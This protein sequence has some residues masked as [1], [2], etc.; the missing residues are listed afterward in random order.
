MKTEKTFSDKTILI[1]GATD[2]L[3]KSVA[4]HLAERGAHLL[5]HGRNRKKGQ[6]LL[7][8]LKSKTA[9]EQLFY[10]HANFSALDEVQ[11]MSN[12]VLNENKRIDILINNAGLYSKTREI[13]QSGHE[14]TMTI[15]YFA[16]VLLTE[17]LLPI[18][19]ANSGKIINVASAS[20]EQIDFSDF[21]MKMHYEG[22]TAYSK[23]KTALIMYTID[24][25]E[26]LK[27]NGVTVN[28]LHPASLMNTNIIAAGYSLST[29]ED[30]TS[31]VEALIRVEDTGGYYNGKRL[32]KAIGQVYD[33]E[34]KRR[35]WQG[36]S[37]ILKDFNQSVFA[38]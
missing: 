37:D 19:T 10:Y 2:G 18:I 5:L 23:S 21:M 33:E 8:E 11:A 14:L 24:L 26:R 17:S 1:T 22:Y 20:Q 28:A 30:G 9:N 25:A 27:T 12:K 35:L 4:T 31:S 15:N 36:T 29:V 13:S 3:G 32:S 34:S 6:A 38:S 16:Q 7:N